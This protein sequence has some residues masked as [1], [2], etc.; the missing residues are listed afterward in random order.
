MTDIL[1][2]L[3]WLLST[4][5]ITSAVAVLGYY[6][7]VHYPLSF[8]AVLVVTAAVL[9]NKIVVF[10]PF[11]VPAGVIV[12]SATFLMTDILSEIW[13]KSIA[14]QA[15]WT[16]FLGLLAFVLALES[17]VAWSPAPFA[18]TQAEAF[19]SVLGQTPRIAL[20]SLVAYLVSQHHDV[21]AYHWWK[22]RYHNRHLWLRNNA[23][24]IVSQLIDSVIF[25]TIAFY[26]VMPIGEMILGMWCAKVIIALLDTPFIYISRWLIRRWI[27]VPAN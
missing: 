26:G 2:I 13:G 23:S 18:L 20:A 7:G 11:F 17:A 8:M 21:W 24:T 5:L 4:L 27:A 22:E 25:L 1:W 12:A 10:G 6:R 9:A 19:G 14:N 3:L 16:G 15:V